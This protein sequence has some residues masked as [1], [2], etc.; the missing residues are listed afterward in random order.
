MNNHQSEMT[1]GKQCRALTNP[2]QLP[3]PVTTTLLMIVMIHALMFCGKAKSYSTAPLR[4]IGRDA[5]SDHH[6]RC[7]HHQQVSLVQ[8][9]FFLLLLLFNTIFIMSADN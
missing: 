4:V 6:Y 8:L 3:L 5:L 1:R 9:V 7:C 2:N